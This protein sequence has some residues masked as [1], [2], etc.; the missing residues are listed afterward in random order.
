VNKQLGV[1]FTVVFIDLLGFGIVLPL[2]PT[3]AATFGVSPAAIGFLVTSFSL[4]QLLAVPLW[5]ALSDRI[6]RRPVLIV[7][8]VGSTAS[9]VLFAFAG[10]YWALLVSRIVAGAMGATIGVAQAYI[11]DVT[12]PERRAQAMGML[13]AAF[14]MGFIVGPALGGVLS[15]HSYGSAGLVAAGLC[16]ANALAALAW[17]PETPQHRASRPR[18]R[19]PLG[20]LAAPLAAS[21]LVTA[22]FAVLHVTLPLFGRDILHDTTREMGMLF[23]YMG[24]VSA[25]V[26]G[27]LV[28]RLAPKV[29]EQRLAA[30]GGFLL[31]VGLALVPVASSHLMLYAMLGV[32]SAGSALATPSVYAVVSRRASADQQG[33]ALGLTQ[34][35]STLGRIAGPTTA[36]FLIGTHGTA[37]PFWAGA[38]MALLGMVAALFLP[39][40]G[41]AERVPV[42]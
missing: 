35:A 16:A 30:A 41:R 20:P 15:A 6:G 26:Q 27:G 14:A 22:A 5:G 42:G 32:L 8:L 1:V 39:R 12:A 23:A 2:L 31:A 18:G 11:A 40:V 17:L 38:L 36:G 33:A 29:G 21:F 25:V 3:Y 34:T 24:V 4:L 7:G 9:Y 13:G 19:V 10:S 28:G 37:A